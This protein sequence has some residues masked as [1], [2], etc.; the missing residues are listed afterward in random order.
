MLAVPDRLIWNGLLPMLAVPTALLLL[1]ASAA[2]ASSTWHC[3]VTLM[4]QP[5]CRL[6]HICLLHVSTLICGQHLTA[7]RVLGLQV[8]SKLDSADREKIEKEVEE[9]IQWLDA[10][11]LAEVDELQHKLK[12][13]EGVCSPIITKMYQVRSPA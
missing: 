6:L 11:Q 1:P 4:T 10:N 3:H 7:W 9:T 13:L 8:A 2:P 5:S 12:E